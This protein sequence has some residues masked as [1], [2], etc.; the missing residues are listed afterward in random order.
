VRS[1][2]RHLTTEE[3]KRYDSVILAIEG[4][5]SGSVAGKGMNSLISD[6][7]SAELILASRGYAE[8]SK[9]NIE[10]NQTARIASV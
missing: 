5:Q 9:A 8:N 3:N 1:V 6:V 7:C 10:E 4:E 2:E